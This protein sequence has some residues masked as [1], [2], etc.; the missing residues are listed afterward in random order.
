[1]FRKTLVILLLALPFALLAGSVPAVYQPFQPLKE[2]GYVQIWNI[3]FAGQ[4]HHV[5]LI[6]M[7]SNVGPGT[8]NN[9]ISMLV[10]TNGQSRAY[11]REH[12]DESL[13]VTP[14][15]FGMQNRSGSLQMR[16][17]RIEAEASFDGAA[18]RLSFSSGVPGMLMPDW[19]LQGQ[20]FFRIGLPVLRAPASLLLKTEGRT[21]RLTGVAGMDSIV[22][23]ALPHRYAKR[24]FLFRGP[25]GRFQMTGYLDKQNRYRIKLYRLMGRSTIEDPVV[26]IHEEDIETEPFSLYRLPRI[27]KL[28]GES[29]CV[30]EIRRGN[31]RGGMY[32]LQSVSPFLRWILRLL[33][34][35][36]FILNYESILR[37]Q[38]TGLP[39]F[40]ERLWTSYFLLNE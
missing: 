16:Q 18:I 23:N 6:Y 17:G 19:K 25:S 8:L 13:V 14:G 20:D 34:A 36:P 5:D 15:Q 29:G 27:L 24:L 39:P 26:D 31:F 33:F 35:K 1:M 37:V 11:T 38:C 30:Y 28:K 12:T 32:V 21:V 4:G 7:I 3:Q 10:Y 9:G 40:T 2:D 22:A